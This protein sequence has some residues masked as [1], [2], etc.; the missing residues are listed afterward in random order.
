MWGTSTSSINGPRRGLGKI[1]LEGAVA[2]ALSVFS[3]GDGGTEEG[4]GVETT[5][6]KMTKTTTRTEFTSEERLSMSMAL[7]RA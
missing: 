4:V 1:K 6:T 3:S 5:N 2:Q 7:A